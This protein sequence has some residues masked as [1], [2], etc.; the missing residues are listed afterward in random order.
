MLNEEISDGSYS[1]RQWKIRNVLKREKVTQAFSLYK[2]KSDVEQAHAH[3]W[4]RTSRCPFTAV[5][6]W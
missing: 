4:R 3:T 6:T 1:Q 5:S 2:K